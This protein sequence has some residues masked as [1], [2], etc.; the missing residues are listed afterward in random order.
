MEAK[1]LIQ[2]QQDA[3]A[4]RLLATGTADVMCKLKNLIIG[5]TE[6]EA[7]SFVTH[8]LPQIWELYC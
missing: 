4:P 7:L 1:K 6:S 5:T 3:S 2:T 8:M